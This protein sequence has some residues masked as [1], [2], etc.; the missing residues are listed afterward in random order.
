MAD[1]LED[2]WDETTDSLKLETRPDLVQVKLHNASKQMSESAELDK[3]L[4]PY[5]LRFVCLESDVELLIH[6]VVV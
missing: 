1:K 6:I 3:L 5:A 4:L 2:D